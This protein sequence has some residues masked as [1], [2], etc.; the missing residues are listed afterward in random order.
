MLTSPDCG[1]RC[2]MQVPASSGAWPVWKAPR[3]GNLRQPKGSLT[4]KGAAG[5]E[6]L[7]EVIATPQG[8]QL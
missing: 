5:A 4:E 7:E 3:A 8:A 6:H 2:T 1:E